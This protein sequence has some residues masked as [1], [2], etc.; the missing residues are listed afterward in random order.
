MAMCPA[1]D[2][3][4]GR[5]V[6]GHREAAVAAGPVAVAEVSVALAVAVLAVVAPA[7]SGSVNELIYFSRLN[8]RSLY[9]FI[10]LYF[11]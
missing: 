9:S 11:S 1:E 8:K 7:V 5:V 2:I 4:T 10:S 6:A 3:L